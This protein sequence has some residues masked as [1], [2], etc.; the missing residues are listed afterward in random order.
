MN[1]Q[2]RFRLEIVELE[3]ALIGMVKRL[4]DAARKMG[5]GCGD[6]HMIGMLLDRDDALQSV[7]RLHMIGVFAHQLKQ[8]I[9][10]LAKKWTIDANEP[11]R[12]MIP[13]APAR[14]AHF[15]F[16]RCMPGPPLPSPFRE[17]RAT[18]RAGSMAGRF[19]AR[20]IRVVVAFLRDLFWPMSA[21]TALR[22]HNVRSRWLKKAIAQVPVHIVEI[23]PLPGLTIVNRASAIQPP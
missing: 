23:A 1:P 17:Y 11:R 13:D 2:Q 14:R 15:V 21:W 7:L 6:H 16:S 12:Q 5:V 3:R 4:A 18:F 10:V 19:A 22:F 9:V 8:L 20:L